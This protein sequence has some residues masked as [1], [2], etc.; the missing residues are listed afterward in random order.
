MEKKNIYL[1]KWNYANK[2]NTKSSKMQVK[3]T[4]VV[5]ISEKDKIPGYLIW[6]HVP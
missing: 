2:W 1:F 5:L 3:D 4:D 6:I